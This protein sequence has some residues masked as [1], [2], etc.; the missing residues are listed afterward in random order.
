MA[1]PV[2]LVLSLDPRKSRLDSNTHDDYSPI[3]IAPSTVVMGNEKRKSRPRGSYGRRTIPGTQKR[4]RSPV[5][6]IQLHQSIEDGY[7]AGEDQLIDANEP[8]VQHVVKAEQ[9]PR[10]RVKS[11]KPF[12]PKYTQIVSIDLGMSG[13]GGSDIHHL[14]KRNTDEY[15][16]ESGVCKNRSDFHRGRNAVA[17]SF[18]E[19]RESAFKGR[20]DR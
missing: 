2:K 10:K 14:A 7:S 5:R 8:S 1:H 18:S 12:K 11:E 19:I 16:N 3:W 9:K 20:D 4:K 15:R 6:P 17:W 13:A